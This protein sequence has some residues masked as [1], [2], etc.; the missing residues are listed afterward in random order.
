MKAS[1]VIVALAV[2]GVGWLFL[3]QNSRATLQRVAPTATERVSLILDLT[4]STSAAYPV[5][6]ERA[7]TVASKMTVGDQ[8]AVFALVGSTSI[9]QPLAQYEVASNDEPAQQI[10]Q[11]K[12]WI[13]KA[14]QIFARECPP[15]NSVSA[16]R[17]K[18]GRSCLFRGLKRRLES[19]TKALNPGD[20][21]TI[22][23]FTDGMEDCGVTTETGTKRFDLNLFI[24][25]VKAAEANRS[26]ESSTSEE[27][28]LTNSARIFLVLNDEQ[29]MD[30]I[31]AKSTP[32]RTKYW[33]QRLVDLP[34]NAKVLSDVPSALEL[35]WP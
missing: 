9:L 18:D 24:D 30:S 19:D 27:G 15:T 7:R 20:R 29:L 33:K 3:V 17:C 10:A 4:G 26:F 14:N 34:A 11:R 31:T 12:S 2:L 16:P 5:M 32:F 1:L 35:R 13:T 22:F 8:L 25:P 23:M 21:S 6:V 28:K